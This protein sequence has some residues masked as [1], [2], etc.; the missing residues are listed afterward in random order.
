MSN[1]HWTEQ[2]YDDFRFNVAFNFVEQVLEAMKERGVSQKD[3]AEAA[4]LSE[5]RV[6]QI[7]NNPGNLTLRTIVKWSRALGHKVGVVLYD[8]GDAGN[9]RG[10]IDSDVFRYCWEAAGRPV[11]HGE[12]FPSGDYGFQREFMKCWSPAGEDVKPNYV[13]FFQRAF[14]DGDDE[15]VAV[16]NNVIEFPVWQPVEQSD[17]D[18]S[19]LSDDSAAAL[20]A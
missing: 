17:D 19:D 8:D 5:G 6:S 2:S 12:L 15:V 7:I 16:P 13:A 14:H 4:E 9:E 11:D 10:P 1:K 3:L 20:N 18:G